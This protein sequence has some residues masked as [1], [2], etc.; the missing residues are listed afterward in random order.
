MLPKE[1]SNVSYVLLH[2]PDDDLF[3]FEIY[4]VPQEFKTL[5]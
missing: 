2:C 4:F 5:W 3:V 1:D